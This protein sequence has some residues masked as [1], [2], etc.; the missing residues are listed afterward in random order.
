MVS[1]ISFSFSMIL[2]IGSFLHAQEVV[3]DYFQANPKES[4]FKISKVSINEGNKPL[5]KLTSIAEQA[6]EIYFPANEFFTTKSKNLLFTKAYEEDKDG[7]EKVVLKSYTVTNSTLLKN[8]ELKLRNPYIGIFPLFSIDGIIITDE[9][10]A[11]GQEIMI[12]DKN[13]SKK[14]S[15][16][17]YGDKSFEYSIFDL[18]DENAAFLFFPVNIDDA[19][20]FVLINAKT[21]NLLTERYINFPKYS[22]SD[23]KIVG[24]FFIVK[25]YE[26]IDYTQI[27]TCFDKLGNIIWTKVLENDFLLDVK[28]G[29]KTYAFII[30]SSSSYMIDI[31][32]GDILVEKELNQMFN[33]S[34][35]EK[36]KVLEAASDELSENIYLS[37]RISNSMNLG[38]QKHIIVKIATDSSKFSVLFEKL[39]PLDETLRISLN[40]SNLLVHNFDNNLLFQHEK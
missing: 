32:T 20:K 4:L 39:L 8:Q 40:G 24:E 23:L 22:I 6:K 35:K 37:V 13:L 30:N 18:K 25:K 5:L 1:K 36:L 31:L 17:P 16:R 28:I 3:I 34:G 26:G 21:G 27:L 7:M 9:F 38:Y 11:L 10:E 15:Y 2:L 29:A 33:I 19:T 14:L 12:F